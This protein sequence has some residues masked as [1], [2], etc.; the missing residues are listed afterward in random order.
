M[1]SKMTGPDWLSDRERRA[2]AKAEANRTKAGSAAAKKL[3]AAI[4]AVAEFLH[5][6]NAC[7]DGSGDEKRGISDGRH[8]LM[9]DMREYA[10]WLDSK[11]VRNAN[12]SK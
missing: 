4:A 2:H 3:E 10:S 12:P 11:Y 5:C 7:Q 1:Q 8:I 6:C 9:R